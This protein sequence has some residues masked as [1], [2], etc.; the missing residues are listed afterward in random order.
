M[1]RFA[2]HL[3]RV[4]WSRVLIRSSLF[5][6]HIY[7][8]KFKSVGR[9]SVT[10]PVLEASSRPKSSNE[11]EQERALD[12]DSIIL[13]TEKNTGK[14]ECAHCGATDSSIWRRTPGEVDL[15]KELPKVYCCDCGNDWV[16]YVA[17]PSL[18]EA[19]KES[20][21]LKGKDPNGKYAG[22]FQLASNADMLFCDLQRIEINAVLCIAKG[23]E[24]PNG[25][26]RK[27]AEAR[28][29]GNKKA[30]EQASNSMLQA[31]K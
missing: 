7:S 15:Q 10:S 9:G 30:K 22:S 6:L 18:A 20:K 2:C 4:S 3:L 16:R 23:I 25:T 1:N 21:K 28:I 5:Q 11:A 19:Q 12:H 8:K 26:K 14:F 13:S 29:A 17:L 27:R 24:T 31:V